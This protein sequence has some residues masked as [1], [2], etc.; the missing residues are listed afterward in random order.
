MTDV[1]VLVVGSGP[2]GLAAA[3]ELAHRGRRVAVLEREA[4]A[5]GI[6]RHCGHYPFGMR[7]FHR[8]LRGPDYAAR[9]LAG[10]VA[11]GVT[12]RTR[13]TATALLPGGR[14]EIT[15][16]NGPTILSARGG[17]ACHRRPRDKSR[18]QADRRRKTWRHPVH[19]RPSGH[20]LP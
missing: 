5:G 2:A 17:P 15:D 6:P 16:D 3:T 20:R 11:A 7:E 4:E 9:L 10:A 1:E 18:V 13:T 14:V 12:I 19:R 8:L